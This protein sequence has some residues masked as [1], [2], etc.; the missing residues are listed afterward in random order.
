MLFLNAMTMLV[1][2]PWNWLRRKINNPPALAE[3]RSVF[4]IT[5]G[6][7]VLGFL[8]PTPRVLLRFGECLG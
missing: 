6:Q 3:E 7:Y 1:D 5:Q 2:T 8:P 4:K